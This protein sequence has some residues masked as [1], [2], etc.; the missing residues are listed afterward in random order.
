[1][2]TTRTMTLRAGLAG[3]LLAGAT[4]L[5]GQNLLSRLGQPQNFAS[6][7]ISSY[8]RTGGNKDSLTIKPGETAVLA[9]I[10]GPAAIHHLWVTI[11]AEPFYGRKIVLRMFWDG[12]TLPS[13]EVPIGD[14]FGVGHGLNRNV[15]S[16]PIACSSEGRAR[17]T[18]WYMPFR[19]SARITATNEGTRDV[20]A[21]YYYVDYREMSW[22]AADTPYFHAQY[23]QEMPCDPGRNYLILDAAG[24]GHYVGCGLSVLERAMGWWG[25]GDD[26]IFVDGESSPS[27]HGTGSEDYFSDA[28]GMREGMNL[29]YGCPLQEEDFQAGSKASVYRF[30]IPD[31][32]PFKKSI[33]VTIEHGHANDRADD[34]SSAAY[35]YQAEPHKAFPEL[36]PVSARLPFALE[37]PAGLILPK[38]AEGKSA[39][40]GGFVFEDKAARLSFKAA[41]LTSVLSPF[42]GPSGARYPVLTTEGAKPGSRS[43]LAV[44]VDTAERYNIE[45]LLARGRNMGNLKVSVIRSGGAAVAFEPASFSG[46]SEDKAFETMT[47]RNVP[48]A[49]GT[50]A[51]VFEATGKDDRALG[52]DMGLVGVG[53]VPAERKFIA[54]WNIIGPFDAPDMDS[55]TV[56]FPP[57]R[58]LVMDARYFGKGGAEVAW[59]EADALPSGFLNLNEL[60]KPNE[61]VVVYAL[62]Y[63]H[64]PKPAATALL[65]GSDDGVR[66]WVNGT[67]VHTNPAY[68]GAYPDQD[69]VPVALKTGW[70]SV[71]I[72]V[73]QGAGGFGLYARFADPDG[74]LSYAAEP[75]K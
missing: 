47:I 40:G 66:A 54:S 61:Q 4:L 25:E 36:P 72:K 46:F 13:V 16:L 60:V 70:N 43:E 20:P 18:Y 48:L 22:M 68:R 59:R 39:A 50:A 45:I 23:R 37:P 27:L 67:L 71:L 35:W 63:I 6:K 26:Q 5:S 49:T 65:L 1:M 41:R 64:S 29:F 32:I 57:E 12:E 15:S 33:R 3:I 44:S 52:A 19:K 7:R 73:L 28:W 51:I 9:E 8:D 21:F 58:E 74:T 2:N 11:S 30:H 17:N 62:A 53:L 31:P 24:R 38:W 55:L 14:F 34:F 69:R 42:Y 75:K 56:A 10:A